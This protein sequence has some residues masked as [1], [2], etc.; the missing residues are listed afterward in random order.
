MYFISGTKGIGGTE[1]I[2]HLVDHIVSMNEDSAS[3]PSSKNINDDPDMVAHASMH[4]GDRSRL[5]FLSLSP[6]WSTE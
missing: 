3:I 5:I 2:A 1:S 4:S 6:S